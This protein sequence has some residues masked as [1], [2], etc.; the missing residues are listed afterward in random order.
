[1]LKHVKDSKTYKTANIKWIA[2]KV[3]ASSLVHGHLQWSYKALLN[4]TL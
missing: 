3:E 2:L 1:M 4:F